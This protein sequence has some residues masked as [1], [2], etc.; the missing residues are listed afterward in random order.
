MS[1]TTNTAAPSEHGTIERLVG[2]CDC[3]DCR[4]A[5]ERKI[6]A[7]DLV[8]TTGRLL[9]RMLEF[10]VRGCELYVVP[11]MI[12]SQ[13]QYSL[14]T[15]RRHLDALVNLGVLTK[16]AP[17]AGYSGRSGIYV[18]RFEKL[19]RRLILKMYDEFERLNE[20]E[21]LTN[22]TAWRVLMLREHGPQAPIFALGAGISRLSSVTAAFI[23][24]SLQTTFVSD[25][26]YVKKRR[27]QRHSSS[28]RCGASWSVWKLQGRSFSNPGD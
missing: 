16:A 20:R 24:S 10:R 21:G 2:D 15:I 27:F 11:T 4:W 22:A 7:S 6:H 13:G 17:I 19:T 3:F 25:V 8:F 9:G 26:M 1:G 5:V 23:V 14:G 12:E 18:L 28:Q